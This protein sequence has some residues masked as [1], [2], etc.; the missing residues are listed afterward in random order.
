MRQPLCGLLLCAVV[1]CATAPAAAD[2]ATPTLQAARGA[3]CAVAHT[4][5]TVQDSNCCKVPSFALADATTS[6]SSPPAGVPA[7][8]DDMEGA[9]K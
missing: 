5:Q 9:R 8:H 4:P 1:T 3:P 6:Q 7:K 2:T